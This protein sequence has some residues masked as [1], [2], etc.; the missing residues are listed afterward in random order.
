MKLVDG[1]ALGWRQIYF[2]RSTI[3]FWS[4]HVA[5]IVGI[6]VLGFSWTG[7]ALAVALYV[8]RMFFAT[9]AYHRY[10]SH[11]S[12]RT[13]RAFQFVLA[14]AAGDGATTACPI[15]RATCIRRTTGSGG[16][17]WGGCCRARKRAPTGAA[18]RT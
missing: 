5:A 13:S 12:Y 11:R 16:R 3:P 1:G 10:F 18:S 7:L 15:A 14:L 4:V 8:P 17:T 9:G 6:A 2:N